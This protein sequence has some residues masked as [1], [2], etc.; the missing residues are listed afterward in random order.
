MRFTWKVTYPD[1]D[2]EYWNNT[3]AEATSELKRLQKF[4]GGKMVIDL[5]SFKKEESEVQH[6]KANI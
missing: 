3:V 1:G 5:V 2:Q 6:G 4:Y